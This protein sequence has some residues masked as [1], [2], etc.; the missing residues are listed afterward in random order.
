MISRNFDRVFC[1]CRIC[2]LEQT[3]NAAQRDFCHHHTAFVRFY[4]FMSHANWLQKFIIDHANDF[5]FSCF[6]SDET[7]QLT[8]PPQ[9]WVD[10]LTATLTPFSYSFFVLPPPGQMGTSTSGTDCP[11]EMFQFVILSVGNSEKLS[12]TSSV[13][14]MSLMFY[15]ILWSFCE[16]IFQ[17]RI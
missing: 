6:R 16:V 2:P 14:A 10:L 17:Y 13:T 9:N 4:L 8:P 12:D 11:L 5:N 15:Y 7:T 3:A 1:V